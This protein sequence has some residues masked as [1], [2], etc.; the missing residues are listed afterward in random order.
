MDISGRYS[1]LPGA[2]PCFSHTP[3]PLL[4]PPLWARPP[5]IFRNEVL[6]LVPNLVWFI[7]LGICLAR[8]S[9]PKG[10]R[11]P[12]L[13]RPQLLSS[14]AC[15]ICCLLTHVHLQTA[16]FP[17]CWCPETGK[18]S[19]TSGLSLKTIIAN[20]VCSLGHRRRPYLLRYC[21]CRSFSRGTTSLG[22]AAG[23]G[24]GG[25]VVPGAKIIRELECGYYKSET[26]GQL[27]IQ[28]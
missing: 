21:L 14:R 23:G 17:R 4:K 22:Q 1:D 20:A 10:F 2:G 18:N 19:T 25:R 28:N 11:S 13:R 27:N 26:I 5:P 24:V 9:P 15:K 12:T 7:Y 16:R 3:N 8:F 6:L